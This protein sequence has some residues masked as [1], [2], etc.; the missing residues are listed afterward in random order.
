MAMVQTIDISFNLL[1]GVIPAALGSCKGLVKLN[2]SH[3][4]LKGSIPD[5]FG[6]LKNLEKIDLSSNNLSGAIPM[7]LGKLRMLHTLNFSFNNLR[8]EIPKEGIFENIA[9]NSL[10]GNPGLCGQ[11]IYLPLCPPSASP[12]QRN[13]S[14]FKNVIIP[15]AGVSTFVI[16]CLLIGL[17]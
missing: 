8:E 3:N 10:M 5:T 2:L 15:V 12:K 6:E 11:Q 7:S 1:T 16:C 9:S 13:H 4:A 14:V 17:L